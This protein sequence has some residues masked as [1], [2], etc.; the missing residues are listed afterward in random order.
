MTEVLS[1]AALVETFVRVFVLIVGSGFV[2]WLIPQILRSLA[3]P[4][5]WIVVILILI[6]MLIMLISG[7]DM[8]DNTIVDSAGNTI[9]GSI[10]VVTTT[11]AKFFAG[12]DNDE[13]ARPYILVMMFFFVIGFLVGL[14]FRKNSNNITIRR[15]F[16]F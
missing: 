11:M 1:N 14:F 6:G 13:D 8:V 16:P 9:H 4:I 7:T 3:T 15:L 12:T 5:K 2:G 10:S